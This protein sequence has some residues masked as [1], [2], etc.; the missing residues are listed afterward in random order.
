MKILIVLLALYLFSILI[1]TIFDGICYFIGKLIIKYGN[2]KVQLQIN[3]LLI[4]GN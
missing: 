3:K 1:S 4:R 2:E